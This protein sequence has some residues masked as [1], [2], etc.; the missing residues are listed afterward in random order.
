M[1]IRHILGGSDPSPDRVSRAV[2][3]I[4]KQAE[5]DEA[6]GVRKDR[7]LFE[8]ESMFEEISDDITLLR[9]RGEK[10]AYR[11]ICA[12]LYRYASETMADSYM[13]LYLNILYRYADALLDTG[14]AQEAM[15]FFDK[16]CA[17][18][19]RLIGS[20]NPYGIH[21]LERYAVSAARAGEKDKAEGALKDMYRIAGEFGACSAMMMAVR[22][23]AS[24]L[25][26]Q[27]NGCVEG[28][29]AFRD[30]L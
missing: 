30:G 26:E 20:S 12:G 25:R 28:K 9:E 16:L 7:V 27:M 14:Q 21:C 3:E 18:T 10:E 8:F 4:I 24:G 11:D 15:E 19:D 22:R 5:R 6:A 29:I 23:F 1:K 13:P 17:G 2:D